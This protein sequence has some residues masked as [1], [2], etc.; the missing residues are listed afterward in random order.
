[1]A[2]KVTKE[3]FLRIKNDNRSDEELIEAYKDIYLD[4]VI[5][6]MIR[7]DAQFMRVYND[8]TRHIYQQERLGLRDL[9]DSIGQDLVEKK[10]RERQEKKEEEQKRLRVV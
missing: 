5:L 4:K 10:S 2:R 8:W 9:M 1:M 6:A 3:I 7:A